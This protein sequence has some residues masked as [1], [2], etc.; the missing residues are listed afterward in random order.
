MIF[1]FGPCRDVKMPR[2]MRS[3]S[4]L[5]NHSSTLVEPGQVGRHEMQANRRMVLQARLD[6]LRFARG[7]IIED[8]VNYLPRRLMDGEVGQEC[9]ELSQVC[10]SAA[11]PVENP[12]FHLWGEHRGGLHAMSTV[13]PRRS[14][15]GKASAPAC[16]VGIAAA[17]LS[18]NLAQLAP[19]ANINHIEHAGPY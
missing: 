12:R 19:S 6:L 8:H 13:A 15:G 16:D 5:A 4:I 9:N 14:F 7:E 17:E 18:A 10:R 2:A 3:R 1:R 11:R